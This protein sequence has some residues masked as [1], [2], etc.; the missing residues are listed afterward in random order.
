MRLIR[1]RRTDTPESLELAFWHSYNRHRD[2]YVNSLQRQLTES[3]DQASR[4]HR[5]RTDLV[6]RM[7]QARRH[8]A[9]LEAVVQSAR[10]GGFLA[11]M[12]PVPAS[13]IPVSVARWAPAGWGAAD[14]CSPGPVDIQ[15]L[16]VLS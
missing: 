7:G 13:R 3:R 11:Q 8:I 10:S 2:D 5:E 6:A 14:W 1:R 16:G 12:D 15:P 9:D 4:C